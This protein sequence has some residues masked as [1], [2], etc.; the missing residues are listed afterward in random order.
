MYLLVHARTFD[1]TVYIQ[2]IKFNKAYTLNFKQLFFG[3]FV[4][5]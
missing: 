2:Y 4:Q 1:N 5:F 3:H